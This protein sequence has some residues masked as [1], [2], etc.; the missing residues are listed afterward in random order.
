V[1]PPKVEVGEAVVG[2]LEFLCQALTNRMKV[3]FGV[4]E[5]MAGPVMRVENGRE[6]SL[7]V[8]YVL[9]LPVVVVVAAVVVAA[10]SACS[11]SLMVAPYF[12][13]ILWRLPASCGPT[14]PRVVVLGFGGPDEKMVAYRMGTLRNRPAGRQ[15]VASH[16]GLLAFSHCLVSA[17]VWIYLQINEK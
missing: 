2:R 14:G 12:C 7:G 1:R 17:P 3:D 8:H 15:F 16:W 9:F 5:R 6:R 11:S 10:V 13:Y 4:A